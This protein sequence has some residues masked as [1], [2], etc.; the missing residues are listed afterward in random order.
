MTARRCRL[1]SGWLQAPCKSPVGHWTPH[2]KVRRFCFTERN[3][4]IN[5]VMR[6]FIDLTGQ[7]FGRLTVLKHAGKGAGNVSMWL[8]RCDCGTEK[9]F[10]SNNIKR[11]N[12]TTSCGCA[13][14]EMLVKRNFKHGD[15]HSKE[16]YAWA[17][18]KSRT[19]N[20]KH[21]RYPYYGGRGIKM[22]QRWLDS[23]QYFLED[24]GRCP[25][26]KRSL[27]RINNDGD[28]CPENCRWE[29][30]QEQMNN[31]RRN[32]FVTKDG[33]TLTIAQWGLRLGIDPMSICAK[34]HRGVDP[35]EALKI[36]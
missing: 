25:D 5:L 17:G 28:Y 8:C 34:I 13:H 19:M 12:H 18:A 20:P 33:E 21:K 11:K 6:Q 29:S 15:S 31:T 24:M 14:S 2:R 30:H 27:G 36:I 32:H 1:R 26:G 16:H 35:I 7:K 9:V 10:Y 4:A 3:R 23:F 22:C